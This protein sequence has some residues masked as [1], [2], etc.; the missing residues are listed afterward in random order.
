M[1]DLVD[2]MG[3]ALLDAGL[4]A[5]AISGLVVLAMVQCRQP[6][7]RRG[8]AR[9]GL[10]STLALLPMA[11][12]NPFPRVDLRAPLRAL[13]PIGLEDPATGPR[14]D[15]DTPETPD[16]DAPDGPG[17]C[18]PGATSWHRWAFRATVGAYAVSLGAGLGWVALGGFGAAWLARRGTSPSG[19]SLRLF[20]LLPFE[21]RA[22]RPRFV[23]S[24][25]ATRPVLLGFFRPAILVPPSFDEPGAADRLR[26]GLLHELA[27]A[28]E[29]DHRF[30]SISATAQAI[31]F[32]LPP[33]WWIRD[34]MILD[35]E[36]LADRRAVGHFGTSGAYASSLVDL[37]Q[38]HATQS[39]RAVPPADSRSV[40]AVEGVASSLIQ[41][42]QMLLRCPFAIER[43]TPLWW[44]W[45]TTVTLAL[46]T[47]A[48]SCLTLRGMAGWWEPAPLLLPHSEAARSFRL[49]VLVIAQDEG[50]RPFDL[51]FRLPDRFTM[52]LEILADPAE[53][54]SV[55]VLGHRLGPTAEPKPGASGS[56]DRLWH[57]VL[58]R[59]DGVVE[60][61]E[62]DG[63]PIATESGP[64]QFSP[65]LTIHAP[66]GRSTRIRDLEVLW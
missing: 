6:A 46:A 4:A 13:M 21:S 14:S 16:P 47:L 53:L 15:F 37:A 42:V 9:A 55:E 52:T 27:H 51:R 58:I 35:Q 18:P 30:A 29:S 23:I 64:P 2:R 5:T 32:F 38:D 54:A 45:S 1:S 41:R 39:D 17:P 26:L 66:S 63:R 31:W 62:V 10:L 50:A 48:T 8:W 7:R 11:A 28:E 65:W 36:F 49:P 33:I 59:R 56:A 20:G 24:S 43:R 12:L 61:V 22:A 3:A 19:E 40:S 57:R 34:Q 44:R 60:P 25:R